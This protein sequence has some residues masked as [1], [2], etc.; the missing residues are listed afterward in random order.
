MQ[1]IG[2][3]VVGLLLLAAPRAPGQQATGTTLWRVA[4]T[5]LTTPPALALGP[6]AAM[7]NPAQTED[8]ARLQLALEAI[9]TP[10]SVD[11][12]GI[13]AAVR[14]P[15][16]SIGQLGLLYGRVGLSDITQ[17]IDSPDPTGTSVPVY[18][19]AVGATW[20]RLV[21]G[22]SVGATLAFHETRLDVG[23]SRTLLGDRLRAAAATHFF[24]SLRTNDPAQDIYAGL[25]GRIWQGP[26][27]RNRVV[28]RGRYGISFAHGFGADHQLGVGAEVAKTVG[29]DLMVSREGGYSDGT[30]WRPA[31]GLRLVIGKYR[32]TLARDAGVN[33]LGSTYR[34]GVDMRFR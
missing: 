4:A 31:A 6:A 32:V 8:S 24:S 20:S 19:F 12:T 30:H 29:L 14:I 23:A 15:A 34:V 10:A 2:L 21:G 17:T 7:W 26:V 27:S 5:T 28:V 9:Q 22:T 13:I 25:E 16:G 3:L 33:D 18:T 1:R 11:A